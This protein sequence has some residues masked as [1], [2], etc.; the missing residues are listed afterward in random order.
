M[1]M[2]SIS[3]GLLLTA[4]VGACDGSGLDDQQPPPD[5]DPVVGASAGGD[6]NVI[7]DGWE[8]ASVHGG[9]NLK[10]M[11]FEQLQAELLR[12]TSITYSKWEENR[13]VFGGADYKTSFQEERT[14]TATKILTWRK[15]TYSVC[16]DMIAK[17]TTTPKLFLAIAPNAAIDPADPKVTAQ[18][19]AIFTKFFFEPPNAQELDVSTATLAKS[20]A[21]GGGPSDA[22]INLCVAY[23]SSMRF[24][25]Y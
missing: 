6:T 19:T 20:V 1:S 4:G 13:L 9:N 10:M 3:L 14:P 11:N 22:W 12:A 17:E 5:D 21:A 24:L 16:T 15:I 18:V 7:S 25:A 23:L 8:T 2:L